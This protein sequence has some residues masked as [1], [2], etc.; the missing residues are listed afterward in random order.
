[1]K[2]YFKLRRKAL[3]ILNSNLP[4]DLYYHDVQHTLDVLNVVN[5]Y[6]RRNKID[7]TSAYLLKIAGLLHDIGFTVVRYNHEVKS[8][9]I[10]EVLMLEFGFTTESIKIVQSLIIAT[11][12][13][14]A[15]KTELEEIL[16]DSDL[17]YLGRKDF[18]NISNK[19]YKE[20]QASSVVSNKIE[21][22]KM[23]IK[24]LESHKYHTKFAK[25]N[26]QPEKEKRI[27]EIKELIKLL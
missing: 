17:D 14:Q 3:E 15:P 16:C 22:N 21:W 12:I 20:L 9:K 10:A 26:R 1:M 5:Q 18:Y 4:S 2:G 6:I 11:K 24:F 27:L 25:K 23:Q 19:L 7:T 13:P 8:A